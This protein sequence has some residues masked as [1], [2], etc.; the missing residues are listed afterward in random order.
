[1]NIKELVEA[2]LNDTNQQIIEISAFNKLSG[3]QLNWKYSSELWSIA[4]CIS[5]LNVTN[6]IYLSEFESK[7]KDRNLPQTDPLNTR[8][9]HSFFGRLIIKAVD[10]SNQKKMKTFKIFNPVQKDF[11]KE[12]LEEFVLIQ[13]KISELILNNRNINFN[14]IKMSSPA[15]K[16]IKE[17]YSDLLEIIKLHNKRHMNQ[18]IRILNDKNFPQE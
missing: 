16:L 6:K 1:M 14:K 11:G 12:V 7:F 13:K 10:P 17:N 8:V 5:H 9:K 3:N 18:A 2:F 15:N 4:E